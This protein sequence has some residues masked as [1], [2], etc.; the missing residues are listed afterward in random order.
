MECRSHAIWLL[1]GSAI[2][3]Y[4]VNLVGLESFGDR[5]SSSEVAVMDGIKG[6]AKYSDPHD[7]S[8]TWPAI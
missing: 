1:V 4:E 2:R 5:L 3:R 6:S 7:S 8:V